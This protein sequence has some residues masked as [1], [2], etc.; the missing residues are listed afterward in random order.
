MNKLKV[1][2]IVMDMVDENCYIVHNEI[3]GIIIDPGYG[4]KKIKKEVEKLNL[5]IVAIMLTHAHFDHIASLEECREY[6]KVDVYASKE[7]KNWLTSPKLNLSDFFGI[8]KGI[9]TYL[10]EKEYEY[11]K[12]YDIHGIKFKV[13]PTPGH[14]PGGVSLDFGDFIMVGDTLFRS[15]IGRFD[16]EGSNYFDLKN[17]LNNVLFKLDGNKIVYPGHGYETYIK[18]EKDLNLI[19]RY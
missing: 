17:S 11:Y 1:E 2:K 10:P 3:N 16:F 15:G 9:S 5:K 19:S 14:S 18:R 4:F 12:D 7:E 6:F 13:L 8:K